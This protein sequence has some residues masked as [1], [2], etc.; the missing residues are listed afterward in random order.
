MVVRMSEELTMS[1]IVKATKLIK[2]ESINCD[3]CKKLKAGTHYGCCG[4]HGFVVLDP[5]AIEY[6][7]EITGVK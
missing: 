6:F 5:K 2:D 7:K 4:V 1:D 3:I